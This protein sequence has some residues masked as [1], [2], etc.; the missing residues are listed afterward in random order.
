MAGRFSCYTIGLRGSRDNPI[1]AQKTKR[2][3]FNKLKAGV[4]SGSGIRLKRADKIIRMLVSLHAML[5]LTVYGNR[6]MAMRG[7]LK[8]TDL[9]DG[10][11]ERTTNGIG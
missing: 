8:T 4:W 6:V 1:V 5:I 11:R 9:P 2:I 3:E 10:K 7:L